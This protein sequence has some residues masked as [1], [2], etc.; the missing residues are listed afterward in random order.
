MM[1]VP[2]FFA[3]IYHPTNI[4]PF[5]LR[6]NGISSLWQRP[7]GVHANVIKLSLPFLEKAYSINS[8][9]EK[10]LTALQGTYFGLYDFEKSDRY[11]KELESLKK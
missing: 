10:L 1:P 11:K 9:N 4:N 6:A 3:C 2:Y 5:A 7:Q 8:K